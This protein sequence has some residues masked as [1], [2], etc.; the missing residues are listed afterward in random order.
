MS[1]DASH[2][3]DECIGNSGTLPLLGSKAGNSATRQQVC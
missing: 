1:L 2:Q 3:L